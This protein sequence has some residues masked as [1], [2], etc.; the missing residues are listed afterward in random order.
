MDFKCLKCGYEKYEVKNI[1]LPEKEVGKVA[2]SVGVYYYKICLNCGF[3]EI[4]S[5]KVID[6]SEKP[7]F[8]Y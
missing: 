6:S 3:V 4:Y 2:F 5:G 8:S 7:T 1:I